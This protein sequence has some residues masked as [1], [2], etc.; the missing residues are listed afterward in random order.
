MGEAPRSKSKEIK[1][2]KAGKG[3]GHLFK[4]IP[5]K[6]FRKGKCTKGEDC[7]FAHSDTDLRSERAAK[8]GSAT[9]SGTMPGP[10]NA[11]FEAALKAV[12]K[13]QVSFANWNS[14]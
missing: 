9:T 3:G 14:M 4:S 13:G 6:Y 1:A 12:Q 8:T 10:S 2:R 5:C 11:T 7:S